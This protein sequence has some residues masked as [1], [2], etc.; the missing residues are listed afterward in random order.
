MY[1]DVE[2][3][4]GYYRIG[5]L[6]GVYC[7][8]IVGTEKA[9]LIDTG[10]CF[11]NLKRAVRQMTDK[12]LVIVNTHGHF[13]HAGGNAQFQECCYI[14]EKD[15]ELCREHTNCEMRRS[16]AKRARNSMNFETGEV[17][18]ALPED[19]DMDA[20]CRMRSGTLKGVKEGDM[21]ELGGATVS[22]YETPGHTKGSISLL[23]K[24]K[25]I[26]FV[27]DATGTFVWLFS[28][29]A[30]GISEYMCTL[31]KMYDLQADEYIGGHNPVPMHRDDLELYMQAAKEADYSRG[32]PFESF[33]SGEC[34][35]R[36]CA[37]DGMTMADMFKPGYA[38]VVVSEEKLE[39]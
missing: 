25:N 13:D 36:V 6:E 26:L 20:Y 10:Y 18:D 35:P 32:E 29:E 12:P 38:A 9:M 33:Y 1:Y 19:F 27:G 17:F 24:E 28:Y 31:E 34:R 8:L 3:M 30:T 15:M 39:C 4:D 37:V 14:H 11:G 22:V 23:Y 7:Y 2:K 5:S 21:F 16:N